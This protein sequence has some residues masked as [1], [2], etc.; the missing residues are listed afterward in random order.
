LALAAVFCAAAAAV[1][2]AKKTDDAVLDRM[3]KD[4]FFLASDKCEGR[5]P[6]TKGINLAADYIAG[7][8]KKAGL[9]PGVDGK[10]YFQPFTITGAAKLEQ[11][12]T[13]VLHGPQGQEIALKVRD[14][15]QPM[16]MSASGKVSAPLVFAGYGITSGTANYDDYAKLDVKGKV[17]VVI[18]RTPRF[19]NRFTSFDGAKTQEHAALVNKLVNAELHKAAAVLFVSDRQMFPSADPLMG[20]RDTSFGGMPTKLVAVHV[21]RSVVDEILLANQGISLADIEKDIDHDLKPRSTP[22]NGWTAD[23]Q[24][25]LKRQKIP[26]K[27]VVGVLEG[28]GPLAKETVIIGAHYDHLGYGGRGS[29]SRNRDKKEI[30]HGA[31]DNGSGTTTLMELARR[32]GSIPKREGRRL[33]FIAFSGE[34][35]GLLG[36]DHYCRHPLFPLSDTVTMVNL[37]MVGRLRPDPKTNQDR[38]E[39]H[40]TGTSKDFAKVLD[41]INK[42]YDFKLNRQ[43]GGIGP[44]DHSSFYSKK[45]PV[46]FFFTGDHP[47]YHKPS[48]TADKINVAGMG[49]I[50][51]LVEELVT[52]LSTVSERPKYIYVKGVPRIGGGRPGPKLGI[53]PGG[54][55]EDD[56]D[57]VLIGGITKGGPADKAGLKVGDRIVEL[58]GKQVKNIQ[59]YMFIMRGQK[60]GKEMDIAIIREGKKKALKIKPE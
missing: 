22:L 1:P 17:V 8:F 57:G 20:F 15:F 35:M 43:A 52:H 21:K 4:I 34:E 32:F 6:Q 39:V 10:S 38:I 13:L 47:D 60:V 25:S 53:M 55:N 33:V 58:A 24:V 50:A 5:G 11:P 3:R 41:D 19:T 28:S 31:D 54:Y 36:S 40:G 9:K 29:L 56:K 27:N 59:S 30:H 44:S 49:K 14:H 26:V 37:D 16:G 45:I 48:D 12:N 42:K 2:A 18:R 7:E 46:Y 51:N 23:V